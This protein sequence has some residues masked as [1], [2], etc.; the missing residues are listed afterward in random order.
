LNFYF[1]HVFI[2]NLWILR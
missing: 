1:N 2:L